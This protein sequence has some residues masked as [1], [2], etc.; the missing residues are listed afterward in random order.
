MINDLT[1][2]FI[3]HALFITHPILVF[4]LSMKYMPPERLNHCLIIINH[5]SL[6]INH[7]GKRLI[8]AAFFLY[9]EYTP[10]RRARPA[11]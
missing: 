11:G 6:I 1:A 5:K 8:K 9:P 3:E 7:K 4:T 10:K 2:G